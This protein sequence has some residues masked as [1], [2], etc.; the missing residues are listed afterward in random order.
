MYGVPANLD[1]SQFHGATLLQIAAGQHDLQLRFESPLEI[2]IEGRWELRDPTGGITSSL[3]R[4]RRLAGG[5]IVSTRINAPRSIVL[6]FDG[7][8]SLEIY[9]SSTQY[10]SFAI[11]PGNV[12]V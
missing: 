8:A 4:L 11:Q 7:G 10:E 5:T 12:I 6:E 1:L 9:D 2:A 3:D